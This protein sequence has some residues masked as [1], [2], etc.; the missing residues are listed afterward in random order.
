MDN[1]GPSPRQ[2]EAKELLRVADIWGSR[3]LDRDSRGLETS[4][5]LAIENR[6]IY[7]EH[8]ETWTHRSRECWLENRISDERFQKH[9]HYWEQ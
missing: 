7:L 4:V 2:K 9:R 6:F 3:S 1:R 8:M 5:V